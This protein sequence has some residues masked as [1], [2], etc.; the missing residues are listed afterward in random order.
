[1]HR[2]CNRTCEVGRAHRLVDLP[3]NADFAVRLMTR[4]NAPQDQCIGLV[5]RTASSL[6]RREPDNVVETGF[7]ISN[8]PEL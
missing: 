3:S 7:G 2:G 4:E 6:R 8:A 1:L 5:E